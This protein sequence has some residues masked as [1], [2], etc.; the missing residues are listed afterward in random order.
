M[1]LPQSFYGP[2]V[3]NGA[4]QLDSKQFI[5]FKV[6]YR[7]VRM[8]PIVPPTEQGSVP[9]K[10]SL[11]HLTV[12]VDLSIIRCTSALGPSPG[13]CHLQ[14]KQAPREHSVSYKTKAIQ[15]TWFYSTLSCI[16]SS[17]PSTSGLSTTFPFSVGCIRSYPR[18]YAPPHHCKT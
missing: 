1:I 2:R 3:D 10:I 18:P 14:M 8:S 17:S 6:A 4:I 5:L 9:T 7:A 11:I 12:N 13:I 15:S 16:L